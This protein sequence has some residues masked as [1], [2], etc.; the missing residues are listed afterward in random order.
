MWPWGQEIASG[1]EERASQEPRG[2]SSD[3]SRELL[4]NLGWTWGYSDSWEPQPPAPQNCFLSFRSALFPTA[5]F[6]RAS[7]HAGPRGRR[8][9]EAC[10][11]FRR[12][13]ENEIA[14]QR[15]L[16]DGK[17]N[18]RYLLRCQRP[19][20]QI[21]SEAKRFMRLLEFKNTSR[22]LFDWKLQIITFLV[23]KHSQKVLRKLPVRSRNVSKLPPRAPRGPPRSRSGPLRPLLACSGV[24]GDGFRDAREPTRTIENLCFP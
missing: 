2:E 18:A 17:R 15:I 1:R 20:S 24:L 4:E 10:G 7:P 12:P 13:L 21:W 22:P 19:P 3:S 11:H 5:T 23:E 6:R 9:R 8:I 14:T 16:Q